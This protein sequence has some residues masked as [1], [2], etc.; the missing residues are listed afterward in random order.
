[1]FDLGCDQTVTLDAERRMAVGKSWLAAMMMM[2]LKLA[3]A[4]CC[5]WLTAGRRKKKE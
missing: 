3:L 4:A 5:L 1:M 2:L